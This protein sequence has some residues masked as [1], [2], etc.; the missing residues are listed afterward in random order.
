MAT[1]YIK[2]SIQGVLSLLPQSHRF[3]YVFQRH[4]SKKL[5]L[6]DS[7]FQQKL[8]VCSRHLKNY[9][10]YTHQQ[11]QSV[12]EL[13]TGWLPII[14]IGLYLSGVEQVISIDVTPLLSDLLVKETLQHFVKYANGGR[15]T[16]YLPEI[17]PERL[18]NIRAILH[19]SERLDAKQALER[20][21]IT[22]IIGDAREA[23]I[24]HIDFMASNTTLEH[25]PGDTIEGI[26]RNF[27]KILGHEGLMSHLI[28]LSD[29]YSHFDRAITPYNFLKFSSSTW[30]IFNNSL[31]YQN[32]L[33]VSDYRK[34]HERSGFELLLEDSKPSTTDLIDKITLSTEFQ[35]YSREDLIVTNSWMVSCPI[36]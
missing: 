34:I 3:N 13:G 35:H 8:E 33:R 5:R 9:T 30:R 7:Y 28:D 22:P 29:H 23:D 20:L 27:R 15:L 1:W 10:L 11:P 6:S 25:I 4:I 2:A 32:R 36:K 16:E 21:H 12:V 26:F 17:K 18:E 24:D 14:P 19:E 31:H